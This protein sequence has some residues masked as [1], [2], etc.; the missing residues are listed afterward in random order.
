MHLLLVDA[1]IYVDKYEFIYWLNDF[2]IYVC[3]SPPS[4]FSY[5]PLSGSKWSE[6]SVIHK[7]FFWSQ[8]NK[9]YSKFAIISGQISPN[10]TCVS[11]KISPNFFFFLQKMLLSQIFTWTC[12]DWKL[13]FLTNFLNNQTQRKFSS[14]DFTFLLYD[15]R[16]I[17]HP[18]I[19]IFNKK[20]SI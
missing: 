12:F 7:F 9:H 15:F 4:P 3:S 8:L 14:P 1:K 10:F 11:P 5:T 20:I 13:K 2:R 19:R 6:I 18:E 17:K 16:I